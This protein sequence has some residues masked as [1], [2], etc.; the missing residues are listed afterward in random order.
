MQMPLLPIMCNF[1]SVRTATKVQKNWQNYN[2]GGIVITINVL[3]ISSGSSRG[4]INN[5]F[6]AHSACLKGT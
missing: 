3:I 4:N 6:F 2:K 1:L 5:S